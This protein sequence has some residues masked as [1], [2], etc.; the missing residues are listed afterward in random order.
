MSDYGTIPT[1]D[2]VRAHW[3][4]WFL[5]DGENFDRWL[6]TVRRAALV[7]FIEIQSV[8]YRKHSGNA[9]LE[10]IALAVTRFG[11]DPLAIYGDDRHVPD[12]LR[13]LIAAAT[14]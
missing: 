11:V 5:E 2:E 1:T 13:A 7:E 3:T 14:T 6:A 9:I 12:E 8:E 4:G 10:D